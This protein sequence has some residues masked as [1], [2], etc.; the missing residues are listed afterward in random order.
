MKHTRH[1]I[2]L[3]LGAAGCWYGMEFVH[4]CGHMLAALVTS[5]RIEHFEIPLVG[6]SR[7]DILPNRHPAVVAWAGPLLGSLIPLVV[8][9]AVRLA[10]KRLILLQVFA[11]FCLLANG[12]YLGVGSFD[13]VGDAGDILRRGCPIFLLW[14]FGAIAMAG[15]VWMLHVLIAEHRRRAS[16]GAAAEGGTPNV[17]PKTSSV[18]FGSDR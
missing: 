8:C 6:F 11:A 5:G 10:K 4:E 2:L 13:R 12:A 3:S 1:I 7:S 15:G 16:R 18:G 14:S 9:A 17:R